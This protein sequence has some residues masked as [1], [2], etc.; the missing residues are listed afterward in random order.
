MCT[1]SMCQEMLLTVFMLM[2]TAISVKQYLKL[3]FPTFTFVQAKKSVRLCQNKIL[4]EEKR[5]DKR[6]SET[7]V[8]KGY[9]IQEM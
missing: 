5:S 6:M 3:W 7:I 4:K 9:N 8:H 1:F 2:A